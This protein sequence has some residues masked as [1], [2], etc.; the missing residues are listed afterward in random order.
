MNLG[1]IDRVILS[2]PLAAARPSR[3]A[4][5]VEPQDS[6]RLGETP[7][8]LPPGLELKAGWTFTGQLSQQRI[9]LPFPYP[10]A[11]LEMN[12]LPAQVA[13]LRA[14]GQPQ[15]AR[16]LLENYLSLGER[17]GVL[18]GSNQLNELGRSGMPRLSELVLQEPHDPDFLRRAYDVLACDHRNVWSDGYFKQLPNGLNRF[19]DVDYSPEATLEESG[20][21][22]N[23]HRFENGDPMPYVPVDLNA[24]LYRT[25]KDLAT[26][27]GR[28]GR[29]EEAANWNEAAELRK[30]L[31]LATMWD[32]D[33]QTFRDLKGSQRSEVETLA[34]LAVLRA[35][36][37]SPDD[38]RARAML[39]SLERLRTPEGMLWDSAG[40]EL[41]PAQDVR[42]LMGPAPEQVG[43]YQPPVSPLGAHRQQLIG[44]EPASGPSDRRM[45]E[46]H[47]SLFTPKAIAAVQARGLT[48]LVYGTESLRPQTSQKLD[49]P[50]KVGPF[51]LDLPGADLAVLAPGIFQL[52]KGSDCL[53][54]AAVGDSLLLGDRLYARDEL[55]VSG[56]VKLP[57]SI[58]GAF[59][60]AGG[61]PAL[62]RFFDHQRDWLNEPSAT[63]ATGLGP[64]SGRPGWNRLYERVA[65]GWE[66]LT[67][68][69]SVVAKD[70]AMPIFHKAAVP[71]LGIFKTQFN[72]DTLFMAMGM[73]WQGAGQ[74]VAGMADNLLFLLEST[75]RVP[76]AARSVYLNKSQPPILPQ[77]VRMSHPLR[78]AQE[79]QAEADLWLEKAYQAMSGDYK[80]FWCQEGERGISQINGQS[81]RLAR[82]GGPN[83][84]FAMDESGFDTTSRFYDR[85]LD[86]VPPDLNAFLYRYS[87]DM[88]AMAEQLGKGEEAD[89]W[90]QEAALRKASVLRLC[91]DEEDG[92]FRDYRF[93]GPDRGLC[94]DQDALAAAAGPLWAGMLDPSVPA[95]KNMIERSLASLSR[96]EKEHG[97][98]ATAE[99]YGHPEMQW[100][101]PSGWA[102]L[103]MIAIEGA[104][105][106]GNY[107]AASR[108]IGKWLDTIEKV[109]GQDGTILERY[110]V[111]SGGPPPVQKGRYEETQGEGPGFGWTNASLP[112]GLVEVVAGLKSEPGRLSVAPHIPFALQGSPIRLDLK[113]PAGRGAWQVEQRYDGESYQLSV[114]GSPVAVEVLTPPLP[115][116]R[117]PEEVPQ[118][119]GR[120][121]YRLRLEPGESHQVAV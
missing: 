9:D 1:P 18:P 113:D 114:S 104:V 107:E 102:P 72:W 47:E 66:P 88:A 64:L 67:I 100:N 16:G 25:E 109:E 85:T 36:V 74:T 53:L 77:L 56:Q 24:W 99:D 90:R 80:D 49:G 63:P 14:Q 73:R 15:A 71:S 23:A 4:A 106:Y 105:R 21:A 84:K 57:R 98:A 61:N 45:L 79:G 117:G 43:P 50:F 17:Y 83:H 30:Q 5:S 81:V 41:A 7:P 89:S 10:G 97:L 46:L 32:P 111:V 91:W 115:P 38:P 11:A 35:G 103:H 119:D 29:P 44:F 40:R 55:P 39:T 52:Q 65:A 76:N 121:R 62:E 22:K 28:L 58:L 51:Q 34:S 19:C 68:E 82:W 31:M 118:S 26:M 13:E 2:R 75:G 110:D 112:W 59:F 37:L 116:G 96:F 86:L 54:V 42:D 6:V 70:S 94:R 120:V 108:W 69:P 3:P 78:A 87:N 20:G 12:D 95:E 101:G 8:A 27:A 60:R 92:M 33:S 93:Q 48:Q